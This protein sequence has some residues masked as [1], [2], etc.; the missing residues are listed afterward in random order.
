MPFGR[1]QHQLFARM[2]RAPRGVQFLLQP[3]DF[4]S[5]PIVDD[6]GKTIA[7]EFEKVHPGWTWPRRIGAIVRGMYGQQS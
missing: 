4:P 3:V 1:E 6:A 5:Q 2:N 7:Q